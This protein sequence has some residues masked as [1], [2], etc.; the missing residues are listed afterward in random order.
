MHAGNTSTIKLGWDAN[1][2]RNVT[3][4]ILMYGT[5]SGRYT[6]KVATAETWAKVPGIE[7]GKTYYFV[8]VARNRAGLTSPASKEITYRSETRVND[9]P[10]GSITVPSAVLSIYTGDRVA[11]IGTASDPNGK[12]PFTYDWNFGASSGI[13]PSKAR[14]PGLLQFDKPGIHVVKLTVTNSQGRSDPTPAVRVI[15]VKSRPNLLLSRTKWKLKYVDSEEQTDARASYAFDGNPATFWHSKWRGKNPS[16]GPHEIQLDLGVPGNVTGFRYLPRQDGITVGNIGKYEFYLSNDGK[17]WGKP[18]AAGSFDAGSL[19]KEVMFTAQ[20]ARYVK[21]RSLKAMGGESDCNVAELFVL[22]TPKT[23]SIGAGAIKKEKGKKKSAVAREMAA[24]STATVAGS[25]ADSPVPGTMV[26]DGKKYR[27]LTLRKDSLP[28]GAKAVVQVSSN[29]LD[30][31]SGKNHTTV[32]IDNGSILKVR[33]NTPVSPD[34]K[35]FIRVK[36]SNP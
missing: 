25:N 6:Q 24:G 32:V 9:T 33:D 20:T 19:E 1:S 22:T 15:I 31:L 12:A 29:L 4:Y 3:G 30:W 11:F 18:V 10:T 16:K 28:V 5:A 21:L 26:I 36:P 35:R 23:A 2:E 27:S 8:V 14:I 13:A 34:A 17:K 7:E